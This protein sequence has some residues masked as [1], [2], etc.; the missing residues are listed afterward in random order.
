MRHQRTLS[1]FWNFKSWFLPGEA[2]HAGWWRSQFLSPVGL[3]HLSYIYLAATSGL[4][5]MQASRAARAVHDATIGIGDVFHLFRLPQTLERR[6]V[7]IWRD[8]EAELSTS[9]VLSWA[10]SS[11]Y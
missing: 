7:D 5:F 6:L 8:S 1:P 11:H 3:S 4:L 2:H 10:R 9:S